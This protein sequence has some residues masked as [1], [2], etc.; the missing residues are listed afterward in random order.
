MDNEDLEKTRALNDLTELV[1]Q[2]SSDEVIDLPDDINENN[3]SKEELFNDLTTSEEENNKEEN[4]NEDK[5]DKKKKESLIDKFKKLPKKKKIII[6]SVSC[7]VL[8]LIIILLII[9]LIPKKQEEKP[10]TVE[11]IVFAK[12]NYKYKNGVLTFVDEDDNS[13]GS[14]DCQN[15]DEKLCYVAYLDNDEDQFDVAINKYEDD[16]S[17]KLRSQIY[18]NRFVF[19]FDNSNEDS[20]KVILY[21]MLNNET[22]GEYF[23][24]K[25]Y[26]VE[27]K[28]AVVLKNEN[29]KYGLF[30]INDDKLSTLIDFSYDY[31][32]LINKEKDDLV[33]IK[34]NKGYALIDYSNKVKTKY[35][36]G[37]IVDYND[38]YIVEKHNDK[39]NVYNY[40]GEEFNKNYDYIR[41]ISDDYVAV[42]DKNNLYIR[43]YSDNKYNEEAFELTNNNYI[44]VNKFDKDKKLTSST[45]AFDVE[46]DGKNLTVKLPNSDSSVRE[47]KINLKEGD[48]STKYNYYSYLNGKLYFYGDEEKKE[49]L[50]SYECKTKNSLEN[51]ELKEC[52][53]AKDSMLSNNYITPHFDTN[54]YIALFNK[55]Y[56]FISD[57]DNNNSEIKFYDLGEN[58]TKGTYLT[59]DAG[60]KKNI[61]NLTLID[62]KSTKVIA[63]LRS[64]KYGVIEITNNSATV[65]LNFDYEYI[66]RAGNDFIVQLENKNYQILYGNNSYSSSEFPGRI[67]NYANQ[68]LVIEKNSK[69]YLYNG[70]GSVVTDKGFDYIDINYNK[71][72]AT[73]L[74][75]KLDVYNSNNE[76][77]NNEEIVLNTNAY[78]NTNSPAYKIS[79]NGNLITV[80]VYK[81]D[82]SLDYTKAYSL[83]KEDNKDSEKEEDKGEESNETD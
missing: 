36:T 26:G 76:K 60:M 53:V 1:K 47:E 28:N 6:I 78:Q 13:L 7:A 58:K 62:T 72:Y 74:N 35:F 34:D 37:N 5:D 55:K 40:T 39:Y 31:M 80:F 75:N 51:D 49:L 14:Y 67:L 41:L 19:V 64:G 73:V 56:V 79:Q 68:H 18:H 2:S 30:E 17:I 77:V 15:K 21:D 61:D 29:D 69:V 24:L 33:V 11:E 82:G 27:N 42:V 81:T 63:K 52:M 66:E 23:G 32:G 57:M 38:E 44:K 48:I 9:I 3:E 50:G 20:K 4:N 70:D 71:F 10:S 12:D 59:I 25:A 22:L 83:E 54:S 43:G 65:A 46:L 45:Y 8:L 16:T